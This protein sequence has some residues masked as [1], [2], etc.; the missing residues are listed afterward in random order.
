MKNK[1]K[2]LNKKIISKDF[3]NYDKAVLFNNIY[4]KKKVYLEKKFLPKG[5]HW[6]FFNNNYPANKL[7]KDGHPKRGDFLPKLDGYKR[8]FVGA[9]LK[10][11][12]YFK[13]DTTVRKVSY[14]DSIDVHDKKKNKLY[15]VNLNH[16][17]YYKNKSLLKENQKIAFVKNNYVSNRVRYFC[18]DNL[19]LLKS[20]KLKLDNIALF[21]YSALTYNS[22]RIHYDSEYV[23][24]Y[25]GYDNLLVHGPFLVNII[26]DTICYNLKI[27]L[28]DFSFRS[29]RPVFVNENFLIKI[30]KKKN[31]NNIY[32][33][34]VKGEKEL[35]SLAAKGIYNN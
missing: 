35:V 28:K 17:Y 16:H 20:L 10:F 18:Y 8:M 23:K 13:Y 25:E 24:K 30:Y 3:I 29:Y 22:H 31:S 32:I 4:K 21:R 5:W 12:E 7:A 19:I 14:V 34:I 6:L 1:N 26:L 27:D 15:L 11:Q 2:F 9:E 33:Y